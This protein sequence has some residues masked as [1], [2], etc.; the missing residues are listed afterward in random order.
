I[1][2]NVKLSPS[3]PKLP[4]I[5]NLHQLGSSPNQSLSVLS[6]KYGPL[7]L[8]H[9]RQTPTLVFSS[10]EVAM[11][12]MKTNDMTSANRHQSAAANTLFYGC[13]ELVF[14]R[15]GEY[16]RELKRLCVS[17]LPSSK[18]TESFQCV[19]G[20]KYE[21]DEAGTGFGQISLKAMD[22]M[23]AFSFREF[24]PSIGWM[25]KFT[26][27]NRKMK[28]I[29]NEMDGFLDQSRKKPKCV[30]ESSRRGKKSSRKERRGRFE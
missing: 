26:G 15:Y 27:N 24:S 11:D 2:S 21:D 30:D 20:K 9:F 16:W 28:E 23:L 8:L 1:A 3:P 5:G 19:L 4:L 12:I 22:L 10:P 29:F 17:E 14:S 6:K 25:D 7:K 18:R 13:K